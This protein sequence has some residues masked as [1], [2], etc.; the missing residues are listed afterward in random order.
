VHD[1]TGKDDVIE[2]IPVYPCNRPD[3]TAVSKNPTGARS[4]AEAG[5]HVNTLRLAAR[6]VEGGQLA[7]I[8]L[9][10]VT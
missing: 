2:V 8:E 3:V 5:R 6:Y 1:A 4:V 9:R 10:R 7:V